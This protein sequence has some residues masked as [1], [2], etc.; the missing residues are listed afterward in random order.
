MIYRQ[1]SNDQ[2]VN[3]QRRLVSVT[4]LQNLQHLNKEGVLDYGKRNTTAHKCMINFFF[5]AILQV[6]RRIILMNAFLFLHHPANYLQAAYLK[7]KLQE[8]IEK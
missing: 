5:S 7:Q 4:W 1:I 2:L 6:N 3:E 8:S